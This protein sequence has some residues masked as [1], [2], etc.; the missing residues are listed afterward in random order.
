MIIGIKVSDSNA[1]AIK[2]IILTRQQ[3][4]EIKRSKY[5]ALWYWPENR[6]VFM[7]FSFEDG[8]KG[9][10][11]VGQTGT[12]HMDYA[13]RIRLTDRLIPVNKEDYE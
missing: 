5:D 2:M 3:K 4:E 7:D 10:V 1:L 12:Y 8:R 11:A 6:E 13:R 9:S